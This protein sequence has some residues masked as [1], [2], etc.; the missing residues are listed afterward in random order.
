MQTETQTCNKHFARQQTPSQPATLAPGAQRDPA[1]GFSY[2][3][4]KV[5][6]FWYRKL[7]SNLPATGNKS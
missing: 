4:A 3:Q 7:S 5:S 1:A 6:S 2:Y